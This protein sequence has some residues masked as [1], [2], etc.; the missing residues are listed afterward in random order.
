M[1]I[2][3][4]ALFGIMV[5]F[6]AVFALVAL[7]AT[8][9]ARAAEEKA[10]SA[11][12]RLAQMTARAQLAEGSIADAEQRARMAEQRAAHAEER[13]ARAEEAA[14]QAEARAAEAERRM[15]EAYE[16]AR[17]ADAAF[18]ER[19]SAAEEKARQ[20]EA[21]ARALLE[22]ARSQWEARREP[23]RQRAQARQGSFQAQLEAYLE[24]RRAPV[25]FRLE[26]EIDR[27]AAPLLN[28]FAQDERV[29]VQGDDVRIS[30]PVDAS[31][32][33]RA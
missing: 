1:A 33:F 20:A 21:R 11:E 28:R 15:Q 7:R 32:G 31:L 24:H 3:P 13:A 16:H 12:L 22:W 29:E 9:R 23:D 2:V 25:A 30:F 17:R 6:G 26:S 5:L 8:G 4:W 18:R 19:K 10:S 14:R 27:M